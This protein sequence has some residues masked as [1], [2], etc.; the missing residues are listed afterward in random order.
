MPSDGCPTPNPA[1]SQERVRVGHRVMGFN[2]RQS[3]A[4]L[5]LRSFYG[6]D[7]T[8]AELVAIASVLA[9]RAN[10]RLDRDARR[11]KAVMV[12]WFDENWASVCPLLH[13]VALNRA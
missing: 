11:R 5:L 2:W 8:Q 4:W 6:S 3:N 9:A 13:A 7:L 12:K 1:V 10:I